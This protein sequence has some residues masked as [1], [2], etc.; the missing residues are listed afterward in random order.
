M[1]HTSL[2][3]FATILEFILNYSGYAVGA[4]FVACIVA[5]IFG[6]EAPAFLYRRSGG[7]DT[8]SYGRGY[9]GGG[10]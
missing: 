6:I 2:Q 4:I 10:Y 8:A 9:D 7:G 3:V 5:D 1:L